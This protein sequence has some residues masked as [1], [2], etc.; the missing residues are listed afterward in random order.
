MERIGHHGF[1]CGLQHPPPPLAGGSSS[2]LM[3]C[4]AGGPGPRGRALPGPTF[5]APRAACRSTAATTVPGQGRGLG[6]RSWRE[7]VWSGCGDW[8]RWWAWG[9]PRSPVSWGC[10]GTGGEG[11]CG[12]AGMPTRSP[13][14]GWV[15]SRGGGGS[16]ACAVCGL[17]SRVGRGAVTLLVEPGVDLV[18]F[19]AIRGPGVRALRGNRARC[20]VLW[21]RRAPP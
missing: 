15:G 17:T 9:I 12:L 11:G 8:L 13:P 18:R 14:R 4:G 6:R 3:A 16:G 19:R 1:P 21:P 5:A 2:P 7:W 20:V 10:A